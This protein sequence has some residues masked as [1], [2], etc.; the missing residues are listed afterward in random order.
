ML[1]LLLLPTKV[2]RS[3]TTLLAMLLLV[4]AVCKAWERLWALGSPGLTPLAEETLT[5]LC[6]RNT[7]TAVV[8][9]TTPMMLQLLK[10]VV[11][12][13]RDFQKVGGVIFVLKS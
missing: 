4:M 8:V 12:A 7:H 9:C 2:S 6:S 11:D 5:L 10:R 3:L 1:L 13:P